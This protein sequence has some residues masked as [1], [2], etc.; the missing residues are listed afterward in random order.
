M[1]LIFPDKFNLQ[2]ACKNDI[3]WYSD[4][5]P[6]SLLHAFLPAT[7]TEPVSTY[8]LRYIAGFWLVEMVISTNHKPTIYRNLYEN[9]A[10]DSQGC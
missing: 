3:Y 5:A 6:S 7:A 4:L 2:V 8:K 1:A 9:T 10:T